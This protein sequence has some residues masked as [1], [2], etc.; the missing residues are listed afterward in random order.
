MEKYVK[1]NNENNIIIY[2]S[3]K[4]GEM[5]KGLETITEKYVRL[6]EFGLSM[7]G[8]QFVGL[9]MESGNMKI[10]SQ[11]ISYLLLAFCFLF[12]LFGSTIC[13][14]IVKYLN[15]IKLEDEKFIVSGMRT[16][17][18]FFHFSEIVPY[19]NSGLFLISMNLLV[20]NEM[21]IAF[22]IT[23]N[24]VS[25]LLVMVGF[26]MA[27]LINYKKQIYDNFG[28]KVKREKYLTE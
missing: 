1:E 3:I 7:S 14:I 5:D 26:T 9:T 22:S 15:S 2:N 18:H 25:F 19:L 11:K 12:S 13:Y 17:R 20:Y 8:F 23:F 10:L 6:Y 16:Y 27:C 28:E 24:I 4:R 21:E